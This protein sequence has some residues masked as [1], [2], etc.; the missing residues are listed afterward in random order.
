MSVDGSGEVER[1]PRSRSPAARVLGAGARGAGRLAGATGVDRAIEEAAEEAIVRALRSPAVERAIVR[2][3]VEQNAVQSAL[4]QALTSDEVATAI[5]R[6]LDT[7]VAD[8]VWAEILA[9]PKAQMLVERVAEA[10]EVRAAIAQQGMGL[11]T[12]VGHRLTSITEAIDDAVEELIHRILSK[13]GH[14]SET[15][16]VGLFTRA[17]AGVMDLAL[18][19]VA[20]S[21]GF[22]QLASLIP[23]ATGGDAGLPLLGAL[24]YGVLA[25]VIG[26]SVFAAFWAL[27][28]QTPGM[29]LLSIHLEHNG[30]R[31]IGL[32]CAL[33]RLFA[34]PLALLPVGLGFLA[35]LLSSTRRGWHDHLARTMVVYDEGAK[36]SPFLRQLDST[37][38][39]QE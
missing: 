37:D 31:E 15:N 12:D 3:I 29:R 32:R 10:P 21:F 36:A 1:P 2:V 25:V 33:K 38:S 19:G 8:R 20:L 4:E 34:I 17:V 26:G 6:A 7:E 35:I 11:V 24:G 30:S 14:D 28:G 27:V 39:S 16:Q 22:G 18:L 5:V 9:G 23:A 13:S